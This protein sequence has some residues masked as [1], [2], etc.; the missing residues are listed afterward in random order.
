MPTLTTINGLSVAVELPAPGTRTERPPL[1]FVHGLL[2]GAWYFEKYQRY[3]ARL[4][5][6][7]YAVNLRGRPGSRSVADMGRVSLGDYV[8]DVLD[9]A[10]VLDGPVVVGHSMGGL[11][12]QKVGESAAPRALVLLCPAPPAGIPLVSARLL[13][14]QLKYLPRILRSRPLQGTFAD[15]CA[16][17][18]NRVPAVE[19]RVLHD[20][21]VADSG[22]VG[23]EISFGALRVDARKVGCPVLVVSG[24]HDRF[25]PPRIARKVAA[26]YGAPFREYLDHAHFIIWEPGWERPARDV[27]H[28]LDRTLALGGHDTPGDILLESLAQQRG[29]RVELRFLDGHVV[30]AKLIAVDF[31]DPSEI[32]YEVHQVVRVGPAEL[33]AVYPGKVAAASL[34]ELGDYEVLRG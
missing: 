16:L 13:V 26:K 33:A 20:R 32:I 22:Q 6:P 28:W 12:A 18:L 29:K 14:R 17:T 5:Y 30:R 4:G 23:R 21:F 1:L 27:E 15:S 25:V 19:Q 34:Q 7:T 31:E 11:I 2:G 24:S 3:F 9:V 8:Q 10:Q